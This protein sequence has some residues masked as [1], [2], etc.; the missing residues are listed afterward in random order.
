LVE[1]DRAD[2][3]ELAAAVKTRVPAALTPWG[4]LIEVL[5]SALRHALVAAEG[6]QFGAGDFLMIETCVLLALAGQHDKC[7][8]IAEGVDIYR[9]MAATVYRLDREAFQAIPKDE[10]TLEQQEQRRL[11]GKIPVPDC[12]YGLGPGRFRLSYC[13]HMGTDEGRQFAE[14]VVYTH[15][16]KNWAPMVPRLWTW[17]APR[18]GRCCN[19]ALLPEPNA[20]SPT[21]SKSKPGRCHG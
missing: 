1:I 20:A 10:L 21:G 4:K 8:L 16:R 17:S 11:G 18:A 3:E 5:A 19:R 13:R 15:Y 14:A 9:D 6:A 2:I 12:G 7:R